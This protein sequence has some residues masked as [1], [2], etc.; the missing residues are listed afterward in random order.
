MLRQS[1][2]S[3]V[4]IHNEREFYSDHYLAEIL[5]KDL[6]STVEKWRSDAEADGK[7]G[8]PPDARLRALGRKYPRLQQEIQNARASERRLATHQ[9]WFQQ[10]LGALGFDGRP[11]RIL[12]D[13]GEEIPVVGEWEGSSGER[14]VA[15]GAMQTEGGL[16][17]DQD[18]LELFPQR[19]QFPGEA[20]P[21]GA[22]LSEP[23]AEIITRMVFGQDRPPRWV[24][25]LSAS[26]TLLIERGK[27]TH[28]RLLRF[29]W[30]EIF[31]LLDAETLKVASALLHRESLVPGSGMALL[32]SLDE[33]SHRHAFG[34]S[35]DLKHAL[36]EAIELLGN[37][38]VR[39]LRDDLGELHED[40][41]EFAEQLGIECLRYMYRLLFLFYIEARPELGY[42]PVDAEAF[43][44]GYSLE[45]L[46]E[47]ELA[48]LATGADTDASHQQKSLRTLFRLAR[49]GF[50]PGSGAEG[51]LGSSQGGTYNTFEMRPLDSPLFDERGAP[52]LARARLRDMVMQRVIESLSLTGKAKGKQRRGRV[53]YGQLG[54]SQL[55]EVYESLMSFRASSRRRI[56]MRSRMRESSRTS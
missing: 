46:R 6:R 40:S 18:P 54:I 17:N 19:V 5:A 53:S 22:A 56:C 9:Q 26:Q 13:S 44:R 55:G 16:A 2:A 49:N 50:K 51:R 47:M 11:A 8:P 29:D 35:R 32:D 14:L 27:W 45:R 3:L 48:N 36:R 20:P 52:L 4:G 12:L 31:G 33:K 23:W 34:V 43:R 41:G 10:L 42:A 7:A 39:S 38:A 37:E 30:D 24:L 25:L 15:V 1:T 21:A 28:R